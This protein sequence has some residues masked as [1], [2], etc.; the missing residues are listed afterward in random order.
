MPATLT[1]VFR[2]LLV[3]QQF[4][5]SSSRPP[6]FEIG[7]LDEPR[8]HVPRIMKIR[9]GV[10]ESTFL[11]RDF[12]K[13]RP[14]LW[15]LVVDQPTTTGVTTRPSD[16]GTVDRINT[17]PRS[18]DFRL[19]LNLSNS[20]FPYGRLTSRE[21]NF[22]KL[23][24]VIRI[25]SGEFYT[26]LQSDLLKRHVRPNGAF[27]DFGHIAGVM[28]CDI[29]L[30]GTGASL[31]G[32]GT[33]TQPI[34]TF[35]NRQENVIYEFSNSPADI[36]FHPHGSGTSHFLHYYQLF[37]DPNVMKFDFAEPGGPPGPNP[38][39]C[40]KIYIG[41]SDESL[42]TRTRDDRL[43]DEGRRDEAEDDK[44]HHHH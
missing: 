11:L 12:I 3:C 18:T 44:G 31:M 17:D 7:I 21:L 8:E 41:Q 16:M 23:P 4:R 32:P 6:V 1:I 34:F 43:N 20:E 28:G 19:I 14:G 13:A 30:N 40:G 27:N 24:V 5:E 35:D 10:L 38:A 9:N 36:H 15:R 26:K 22:S 25:P 37:R 42:T 39:L 29:S 2:G 33:S